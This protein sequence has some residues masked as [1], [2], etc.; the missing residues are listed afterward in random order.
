MSNSIPTPES[1]KIEVLAKNIGRDDIFIQDIVSYSKNLERR[2]LPI[3]FSLKHFC[4]ISN[5]NYE[6]IIKI[7]QNRDQLYLNKFLKKKRYGF[8]HIRIPSENLRI[9]HKWIK[10]HILGKVEMPSYVTAYCKNRSIIDNATLHL[11]SQLLIK[12][13]LSDFYDHIDT[14]IVYKI[15]RRLGYGKSVSI[16]M[17]EF[18]CVFDGKLGKFVLPQGASTSPILSNMACKNMDLRLNAY[19]KQ[20]GFRYSRYSDDITFSSTEKLK[21][22]Y[23]EIIKIIAE[24]G[25]RVNTKKTR[26]LTKKNRQTVTGLNINNGLSISKRYRKNISTHVHNCVRFGVKH[27]LEKLGLQRV[28]YREWLLGNIFYIASVHPNQGKSLKQKFDLINWVY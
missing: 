23:K 9:I 16:Y 15:F 25:F 26:F 8:R 19:A 4:L 7:H 22:S 20:N 6:N 5:L 24:S 3:L 14:K 28:N 18:C 10:E 12:M 27:H 13:D 21:I 1:E 2:G 17:S 11:N